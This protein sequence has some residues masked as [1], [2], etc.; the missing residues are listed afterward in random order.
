MYGSRRVVGG[1]D[2]RADRAVDAVE[3][4][5]R[6]DPLRPAV[7]GELV[8]VGEVGVDDVRPAV[9]LLDDQ[10]GVHVAEEDVAGRPHPGVLR[11]A[12]HLGDDA[13]ADGPAGLVA[14][15][16]E[17]GH[18]HRE[19]AEIAARAEEEPEERLAV[20]DALRLVLDRR[21]RDVG[22]RR[23][24]GH[25]VADA[26]AVVREQSLAVRQAPDDLRRVVRVARDHELLAVALVPA[27]GG[28][29]VVRPV[30]DAG[31]AGGRHRRQDRLPAGQLVGPAPDPAGHRVDRPGPDPAG[32][33]RV[34]QPIDLD[35]HQARLVGV[36]DVPRRE[37]VLDQEAEE[38][39]A[40]VDAQ[41]RR[42][43]G[44]HRGVDERRDQGGE[45]AVDVD[46]VRQRRDDEE[47]HDLED[48]DEDSE[49]H[50][51]ARGGERSGGPAARSR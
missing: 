37:Q 43:R 3:R 47:R 15:L 18:E 44:V 24:A 35:D 19:R 20:A 41:D 32:Q 48:E 27:E 46:A 33:D 31:L 42:Q 28:D 23:V 7:V 11:A 22:P 14:L 39:A 12:M 10:R 8:V 5:E 9:H 1:L 6:L 29:P 25:Q 17:L 16:Q 49:Q 2:E 34:G 13:G 21:G 50:E 51:R 36:L 38:R 45:E 40:P 4:L 26:H 30:Q